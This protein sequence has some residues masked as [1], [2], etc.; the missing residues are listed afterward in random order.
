MRR[1][2]AFAFIAALAACSPQPA[3]QATPAAEATAAH[4]VSGLEVIPLRVESL[5]GTHRFEVEVAR[6]AE[7]QARG[8]MFRTELGPDQGMLFPRNPPDHASFWMKNTPLPLDIIFIGV[9]GRINNIAAMTTPYSLESVRSEGLA[10][11]VL[12]IPG[13]R[14]AELG[15]A[16]GDKVSW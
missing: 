8:L 5:R 14:A 16:A 3:A 10:S 2:L 11:G 13:G 9:D 4:P 15:I 1:S 7:E 6:S 12:E